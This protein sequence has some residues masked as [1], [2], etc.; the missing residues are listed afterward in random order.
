MFGIRFAFLVALFALCT[1][2]I[3]TAAPPDPGALQSIADCNNCDACAFV[4]VP[5]P[6][7]I[8]V[9]ERVGACDVNC[10]ACVCDLAHVDI[11]EGPM[12]TAD[13]RGRTE[14]LELED[15]SPDLALSRRPVTDPRDPSLWGVDLGAIDKP[16][17]SGWS[18]QEAPRPAPDRSG[19]LLQRH[20]ST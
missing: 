12:C 8:A 18:L 9:V 19:A 16:R 1:V 7:F 3:A 5:A 17:P 15:L 20:L 10:G 2:P 14:L 13:G 4:E 11:D 6:A